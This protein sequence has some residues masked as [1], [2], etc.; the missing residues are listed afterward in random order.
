[1]RNITFIS[2]IIFTL[3]TGSLNAAAATM[4]GFNLVGA[5]V[6]VTEILSGGPPK[7]G[8]PAIDKPVFVKASVAK[9]MRDDERVL[10]IT[11]NGISK[12]YPISI[13]NYHEIVNDR[14]GDEAIAVTYCPLCG[15]GVAFKTEL[16]GYQLQFGVSGLLYNSDVLLYDRRTNSLWSQLL[17]KAITG[18]LKG[19][20]LTRI[21]IEHTTWADWRTQNPDT[22]VLSQDTGYRRDYKDNPYAGYDEHEGVYFPVSFRAQGYHPK[23][24][25]LGIQINNQAKAYPFV[26][27]AKAAKQNVAE[28]KDE[29]AGQVITVR[30]DKTHRAVKAF[31]AE[32]KQIAGTTL[33]WFAWFTFNPKTTVFKAK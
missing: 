15:S 19:N 11:R 21:P 24:Q 23:E 30:F 25:V 4:N 27:L 3:I 2:S 26:E 9:N 12:A 5:L 6:P 13:M 20:E 16:A 7:D 28:I 22:L 8:I 1:M 10:A 29:V 32:G 33:Y 17:S 31:D 18:P 14:F